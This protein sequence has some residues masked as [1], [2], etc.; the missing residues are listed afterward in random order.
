MLQNGIKLFAIHHGF[1]HFF[2]FLA[3]SSFCRLFP[4][5]IHLR[6][7]RF[8]LLAF[9]SPFISIFWRLSQ[10]GRPRDE[11]E[12]RTTTDVKITRLQNDNEEA[13]LGNMRPILR[14]MTKNS[15]GSQEGKSRIPLWLGCWTTTGAVDH[16]QNLKGSNVHT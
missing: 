5:T 1:V 8:A 14:K 13:E 7:T 9:P 10:T 2:P 15:H 12:F 3:S 16:S 6:E 11:T 4:L